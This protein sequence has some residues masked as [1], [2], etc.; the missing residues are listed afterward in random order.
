MYVKFIDN[1]ESIRIESHAQ[2]GWQWW[3]GDDWGELKFIFSL[4]HTQIITEYIMSGMIVHPIYVFFF[5]LQLRRPLNHLNEPYINFCFW[6]AK[7]NYTFVSKPRSKPLFVYF[8]IGVNQ[9]PMKETLNYTCIWIVP[10]NVSR[11]LGIL[12]DSTHYQPSRW[13]HS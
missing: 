8:F 4:T 9:L 3:I 5:F 2:L 1:N 12:N 6:H 7:T 11:I 10:N 13:I